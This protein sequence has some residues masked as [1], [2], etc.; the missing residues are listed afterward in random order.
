LHDLVTAFALD[1]DDA[2]IDQNAVR[3]V[4]AAVVPTID[5]QLLSANPDIGVAAG[6]VAPDGAAVFIGEASG[7]GNA[8]AVA[9]R[10]DHGVGSH[11]GLDAAQQ[12]VIFPAA[13]ERQ[14]DCGDDHGWL[15]G[16]KYKLL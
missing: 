15:H 8:G 7:F 3:G 14:E 4:E 13:G 1:R 5:G 16:R 6:S 10:D 11:A 12:Q 9:I 2:V